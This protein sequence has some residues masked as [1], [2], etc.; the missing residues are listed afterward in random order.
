[1][2]IKNPSLWQEFQFLRRVTVLSV[3]VVMNEKITLCSN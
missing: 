1:M 2:G 3:I